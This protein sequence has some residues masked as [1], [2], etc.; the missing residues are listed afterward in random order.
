MSNSREAA[1]AKETLA[2]SLGRICNLK[3]SRVR[4][5]MAPCSHV[6]LD[7]SIDSQGGM[8]GTKSAGRFHFYEQQFV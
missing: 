2:P 5:G 1:E 4:S 8:I 6:R 3:E 7:Q